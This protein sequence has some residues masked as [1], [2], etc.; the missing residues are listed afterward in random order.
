[1]QEIVET[2]ETPK[3][4]DL[5]NMPKVFV[6]DGRGI[7]TSVD[8]VVMYQEDGKINCRKVWGVRCIEGNYEVKVMGENGGWKRGFLKL[9]ND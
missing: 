5:G 9:A 4:K 1:M 7:L 2:K 8:D 6:L 3:T